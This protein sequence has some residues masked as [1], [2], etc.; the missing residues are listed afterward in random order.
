MPEYKIDHN[1]K[2]LFKALCLKEEELTALKKELRDYYKIHPDAS[3]SEAFEHSVNFLREKI[4][5][6]TKANVT[7]Y[8]MMLFVS[9][10]LL[11]EASAE[12]SMKKKAFNRL[13][14]NE[15]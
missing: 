14:R 15:G 13:F 8:E 2:E 6:V 4:L 11:G 9:G 1:K 5:G 7:E 12:V 10:F 3:N